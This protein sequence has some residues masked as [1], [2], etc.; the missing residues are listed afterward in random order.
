MNLG[1]CVVVLKMSDIDY[2]TVLYN[3]ANDVSE[4]H[5]RLLVPQRYVRLL[6]DDGSV[7]DLDVVSVSKDEVLLGVKE[8]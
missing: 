3:L 7:V 2:F 4:E 1:G 8:D 5:S 6:M